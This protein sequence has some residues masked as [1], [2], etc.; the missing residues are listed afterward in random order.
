MANGYFMRGEIYDVRMDNGIGSEQ[1]SFRPGVIISND[2][3]NNADSTVTVALTTTRFSRSEYFMNV[4]TAATG[5]MSWIMCNQLMTVDKMRL[6][7]FKGVLSSDERRKLDEVLEDQFDLGYVDDKALKEKESEIADLNLLIEER[8]AEVAGAKAAVAKKDEEIAS[9]KMEIEMWQKCYGR[10]MDMLVDTKVSA[11]LQR[12]T[13]A[14][15]KPTK[16]VDPEEPVL[17]DPPK[18]PEPPQNPV[19]QDSRLDINNCTATALKK[20]GFSLSLA[21]KI[22]ESRPFKSVEDLKRVN[23]LKGSQYRI[24]EPK[25]CCNPV[26]PK[27]EFKKDEPDP[28]Y[29]V[30]LPVVAEEPVK[31]I[32]INAV[33]AKE[34]MEVTG[35]CRGT[36]YSITGYRKKNG[37]F[38]KL[39]DLLNVTNFSKTTLEKYGHLFE[40]GEPPAEEPKVFVRD[41]KVNVNTATAKEI[42]AVTGIA[43]SICYCIVAYRKE[44]GPYQSLDDL[45]KAKNVFPGTINARRHL[46]EV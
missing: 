15:V 18:N 33:S 31:K 44:H 30:E 8:K 46:M 45:T 28:G 4:E 25:L 32:N 34:F 13:E 3:R 9:L 24:M 12:R 39:E 5:R 14:P 26:E 23:G 2:K 1:G 41:G 38:K 19:E 16:I 17:N 22:V 11:D 6:G 29:E 20:I 35:L 36:A 42:S 37:P 27:V 43:L 40:I 10:C 21:R 7:N